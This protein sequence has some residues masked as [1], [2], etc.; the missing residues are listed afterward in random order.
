MIPTDGTNGSE[1][2]P[3]TLEGWCPNLKPNRVG[4]EAQVIVAQLFPDDAEDGLEAVREVYLQQLIRAVGLGCHGHGFVWPCLRY[5]R[6]TA[7]QS[8][9]RGTLKTRH[10]FPA[11]R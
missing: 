1:P 4:G 5:N 3:S 10:F 8:R 6:S 9:D 2:R 11:S 7:T